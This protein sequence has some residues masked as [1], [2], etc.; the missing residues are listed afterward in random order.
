MLWFGTFLFRV[1]RDLALLPLQCKP[2][3]KLLPAESGVWA[4]G[5]ASGFVCVPPEHGS[6]AEPSRDAVGT[7][8]IL[9]RPLTR[10]LYFCK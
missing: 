2:F 1:V 3:L 6:A 4:H 9:S 10:L 8:E 5:G 7:Q